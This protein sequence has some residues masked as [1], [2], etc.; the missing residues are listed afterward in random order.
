VKKKARC[1]LR[2]YCNNPFGYLSLNQ[3]VIYAELSGVFP[4]ELSYIIGMQKYSLLILSLVMFWVTNVLAAPAG[5]PNSVENLAA[6]L[7][8]T[9][10]LVGTWQTPTGVVELKDDGTIHYSSSD[11]ALWKIDANPHSTDFIIFNYDYKNGAKEVILHDYKVTDLNKNKITFGE[12]GSGPTQTWTRKTVK[13]TDTQNADVFVNLGDTEDQIATK[14]KTKPVKVVRLDSDPYGAWKG[15]VIKNP[16][17]IVYNENGRVFVIIM[18]AGAP[19]FLPSSSSL[20]EFTM[21]P[22]IRETE[23]NKMK[24]N[25]ARNGD[26]FLG[27]EVVDGTKHWNNSHV[28]IYWEPNRGFQ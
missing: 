22:T 4:V 19:P 5:N 8:I 25:Y 15:T 16:H 14:F 3:Q 24:E 21:S 18:A 27:G 1:S 28:T 17:A 7:K 26:E 23:I 9:R 6:S 11:E 13:Q 10:E 20:C 12:R 2:H